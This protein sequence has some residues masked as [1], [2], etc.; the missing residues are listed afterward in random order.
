MHFGGVT[1]KGDT[2]YV[3]SDDSVHT[4]SLKETLVNDEL[5]MN[6]LMSVNSQA[7]FIDCDEQY[8]YVG[9]FYDLEHNY[10]TNNKITYNDREYNAIVE[11]YS[12]DDLETCL[13]VY[14]IRDEVQGFAVNDKGDML[15]S[16][17]YGLTSSYFYFY[18]K[19]SIVNTNTTYEKADNAPLYV[20]EN[21]DKLLIGPAMAEDLDYYNGKFYTNFE[22]ASNKYIFGK[23]FI[24]ADKIVALDFSKYETK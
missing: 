6:Y 18:N 21:H 4:V 20:L 1:I 2:I 8:L 14:A 24:S 3:A 23:F 5:K 19:D 13:E 10:K 7:S 12:F 11:K 22:S 9:E 17:S 16:C 15:L